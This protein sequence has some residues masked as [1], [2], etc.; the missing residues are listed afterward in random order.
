LIEEIHHRFPMPT[1]WVLLL[2]F[3]IALPAG[4][5]AQDEPKRVLVLYSFG[6]EYFDGF[7][8]GLRTELARLSTGPVEL[9]EV[10]LETARFP[11]TMN[12]APFVDYLH[13]LF[14]E[15]H[16][17]LVI[18]VAGPAARFCVK[19]RE[20]LFPS[21]PMVLGGLERR[22]LRNTASARLTTAVPMAI[23]FPLAVENILRV[24]P[25]TT[26]IVVVLGG[27]AISKFWLAET[28]REFQSLSDRVRFAWLH[29]LSLGE[30]MERVAALPPHAAILFGEYGDIAGDVNGA[31]HP[32]TSLHR[33]ASAP[34]F[35]LFDTQFGK[36]IVGGPLLS[37]AEASRQT[38]ST[39]HR[40]LNGEALAN[41]EERPVTAGSPVYDFRELER[42]GIKEA[43]LPPGSTV[44]FRP[45]S[46]WREYR[47]PLAIGL[48]VVAMQ[49]ALIAGLLLHRSGR[50]AAEE[51]VRALAHR[52]LTAHEDERRR[53]ARELHDDLSQRLARLSIDAARVERSLS[54]SPEKESA[55]TMRADI[56]RL[57]DD[58]HALAYQLHP[59]VLDDLGL[60]EAL[61]VECEQFARRES[62]PA[63]LT[64]FEAPSEL[65]AEVSVCLFRIAQEALRNAAR[66][67]RATRVNLEVIAK[68]GTVRMTVS[69]DGV[70]FVP[71]QQRNRSL[72]HAS[73]R[74]RALLVGGTLEIESAPGRGTT[75]HVSVPMKKG[76][77]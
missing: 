64:A 9:F 21:T 25:D 17:D 18:A 50:Q 1:A 59:S 8:R 28:Q 72:G 47:V 77:P 11:E 36:G 76:S 29:G 27:S 33:A 37:E 38:A 74:E 7:G 56:G 22:V 39:A 53:L 15:R 73:M 58:V 52:L 20:D 12:E 13:A 14:A 54:P 26:D 51:E 34:I 62:I 43:L 16:P 45:P 31:D 42:W 68:N 49:T 67:S 5:A 65:P 10:S 66:H 30:M 55:R 40:I 44:M 35:G 3:A 61:K 60:N 70:G 46:L 32:L 71:A 63:R 69:D 2:I 41:I 75:V 6:R 48:S 19:H 4:S 24:A 23:D 57:G